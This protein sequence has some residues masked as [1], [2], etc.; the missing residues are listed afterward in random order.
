MEKKDLKIMV[1]KEGEKIL[2]K[3]EKN[4]HELS[5]SEA[6]ILLIYSATKIGELKRSDINQLSFK[7]MDEKIIEQYTKLK[8]IISAYIEGGKA[9][10]DK[11]KEDVKT[12]IKEFSELLEKP[13]ESGGE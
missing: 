13:E 9:D 2:R 3:F 12:N 6:M 4:L 5:A 10:K 11:F 7:F 1:E 8:E